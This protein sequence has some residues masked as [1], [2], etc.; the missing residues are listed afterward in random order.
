MCTCFF[1][2]LIN[3]SHQ[4]I[5][6]LDIAYFGNNFIEEAANYQTTSIFDR[7]ATRHQIKE[8]FIIKAAGSTSVPGTD[9]F[10]SFDF[11]VRN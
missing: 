9:D 7:D 2:F 4:A 10:A 11:E 1:E 6:N 3:A 8:L 5:L